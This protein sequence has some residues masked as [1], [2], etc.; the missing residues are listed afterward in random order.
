M[1]GAILNRYR[2]NIQVRIKIQKSE[3][4]ILA[5]RCSPLKQKKDSISKFLHFSQFLSS[6]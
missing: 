2:A 3:K 6:D 4:E 5:N 1:F